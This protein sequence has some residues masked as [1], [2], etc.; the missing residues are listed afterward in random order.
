MKSVMSE[1]RFSGKAVKEG[2]SWA[3]ATELVNLSLI[4][5][6]DRY[7]YVIGNSVTVPHQRSSLP[8]ALK[9]PQIVF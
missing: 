7:A 8:L 3:V 9:S 2:G 1:S 4:L 5:Q 6:N